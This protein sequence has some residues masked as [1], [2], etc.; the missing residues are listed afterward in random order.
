MKETSFLSSTGLLEGG[1]EGGRE[2]GRER[3]REGER[4]R[5]RE[6]ERERGREGEREGGREGGREGERECP[7]CVQ[8]MYIHCNKNSYMY[9]TQPRPSPVLVECILRQ[10]RK[11][12]QIWLARRLWSCHRATCV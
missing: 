2:R 11:L 10:G 4:E 5:G 6:G 9:E 1:S 8:H 7:A 12:K 3:G